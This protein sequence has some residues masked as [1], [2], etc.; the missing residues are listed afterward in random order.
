MKT[1]A[2]ITKFLSCAVAAILLFTAIPASAVE[3][4]T[5]S[6][7]V[8]VYLNGEDVYA[9]SDNKPL[10]IND[11][12]MVP[13]RPIFEKMGFTDQYIKWYPE[14]KK[15]SFS[16]GNTEC[17][18][19]CDSYYVARNG[20]FDLR[21]EVTMDVPA[22]IYN[23]T[24]YIPLRAYC[25]LWDMDIEWDNHDR[26]VHITKNPAIANQIK[27]N[28]I[29]T[30][31]EE[32]LEKLN[33]SKGKVWQCFTSHEYEHKNAEYELQIE[34]INDNNS[35]VTFSL[36]MYRLYSFRHV[37][38]VLSYSGRLGFT[39]IK[40]I[41]GDSSYK[42]ITGDMKFQDGKLILTITGSSL[43]YI[44]TGTV[45]TFDTLSDEPTL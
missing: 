25:E 41:Q 44:E 7:D 15:A 31:K 24:F 19:E 11:R 1:K 23:D 10:I 39:S 8:K 26:S 14:E 13:L 36:N 12:T 4:K 42:S 43:D 34:E 21:N 3:I 45:Y 22:T 37:T 18:F 27:T 5:F 2:L 38:A 40:P 30:T 35:F 32:V 33:A 16:D 6:E 17:V 28:D 20:V 29:G 9:D